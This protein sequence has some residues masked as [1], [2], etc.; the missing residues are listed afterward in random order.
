MILADLKAHIEHHPGVTRQALAAEFALSE[1][2]VEAMLE[3]WIRKGKLSRTE[4]CDKAGQLLRVRYHVN[5]PNGLSIQ[6]KM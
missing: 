4:D 5:Q 3:V 1:D 6:V 2:G